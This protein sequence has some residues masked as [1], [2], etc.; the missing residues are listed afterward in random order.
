MLGAALGVAAVGAADYAANAA[1]AAAETQKFQLALRG[2]TF[3]D[4][5]GKALESVDRLSE[6][7]Q[8]DLGET[9]KQFTKLTA[10]ATANG[11]SIKETEDIYKGL[12]SAK[13][14]PWR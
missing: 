4:D 6:D 9:T 2:I 3:G 5:Y 12:A 13:H 8:Q 1:V 10:A 14:C 11:L 7:F